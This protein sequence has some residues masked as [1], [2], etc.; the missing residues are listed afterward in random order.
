[1]VHPGASVPAR[2]LAADRWRAVVD[3]LIDDGRSVLVTGTGAETDLVRAVAG[4][5]AQVHLSLPLADLATLLAGAAALA[6]G[7]TGPAHLAAAV[8]TPV[9]EV[10]PPTVPASRWRPWRVPSVLLGRQSIECSGCRHRICPVPGQPC[11]ATIGAGDVVA[12]I[13]AVAT[14][15]VAP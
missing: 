15:G 9:V 2:T 8:G 13:D 1:V 14:V 6:V 7:N 5:R 3:H 4:E 12:A 10:F 11:T